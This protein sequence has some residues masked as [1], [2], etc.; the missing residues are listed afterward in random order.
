MHHRDTER[1]ESKLDNG[2]PMRWE[3]SLNGLY[4]DDQLPFHDCV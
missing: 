4:L 3:E 1:T 2:D